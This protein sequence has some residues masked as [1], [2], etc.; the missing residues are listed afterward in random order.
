MRIAL[1]LERAPNVHGAFQ[2]ALSMVLA[3]A[4]PGATAHEI[5]VFTQFEST[6]RVLLQHGVRALRFK[7]RGIRLLDMWSGSVVGG[8]VLRRL[9]RLGLRR[10]GRHLDALLDDHGIA[11]VVLTECSQIA[12]RIG[13]HPFMVTVWDVFHRDHPEFPEIYRN[14]TFEHWERVR[15]A[16]LTR[17]IGV[18]VASSFAARRIARLYQVDPQRIIVLPFLPSVAVRR[19]AAGQG[20]TTAEGVRHKYQ[21]PEP[22]VFYPAHSGALKNHLYLLEALVALERRHGITLQAV[23]CGEDGDGGD[24]GSRRIVERQAQALG[25]TSRVRFLGAVQD[26]DIPALYEGAFALV[27][28]AYSG[29]TNLPPLEAVV[30]GCPVIY[31]NLPE[32]REQMGDAALYCDLADVSSLADHLARL[33]EDPALRERLRSSGGKLAARIARIDYGQILKPM[34]DDF[35]CLRRRWAWP[36]DAN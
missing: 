15:S 35:V 14:R 12:Y 2:Q 28:P 34:F 6:R 7:H 21:L 8:A 31:S 22:Y 18:I 30:L 33:T 4:A 24:K 25:L 13:D 10:L 11:L 17:A 26:D 23:F 29:P 3:L 36:Q 1:F 9:R 32:F 19:Y 20:R 5:V 27:M 16:T